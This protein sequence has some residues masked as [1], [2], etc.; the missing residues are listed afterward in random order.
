MEIIITCSDCKRVFL[1][2]HDINKCPDQSCNSLNVF[3][4]IK[5]DAEIQINPSIE[6][7]EQID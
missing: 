4:E 2:K 6:K 7:K 5:S 3:K 1:C